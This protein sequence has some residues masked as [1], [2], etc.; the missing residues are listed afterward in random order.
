[1]PPSNA[2]TSLPRKRYL[3]L[4]RATG[5]G[6]TEMLATTRTTGS[7][8]RELLAKPPQESRRRA[9]TLAGGLLGAGVRSCR[10]SL[11]DGRR[12]QIDQPRWNAIRMLRST[13]PLTVSSLTTP[14]PRT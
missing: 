1:Q 7:M 4:K 13:A 9:G 10:R 8:T 12:H 14:M 5:D 2:V 6:L 3:P 11:G